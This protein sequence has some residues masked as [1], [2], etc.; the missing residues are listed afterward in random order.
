MAERNGEKEEQET[1]AIF[2][3]FSLHLEVRMIS[4]SLTPLIL[5]WSLPLS[6]HL[7]PIVPFRLSRSIL[8]PVLLYLTQILRATDTT[9]RHFTP[10]SPPHSPPLQSHTNQPSEWTPLV[11]IIKISIGSKP[12]YMLQYAVGDV[13]DTRSRRRE[14]SFLELLASASPALS[15]RFRFHWLSCWK[16][17]K[18][19]LYF[20]LYLSSWSNV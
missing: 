5:P 6:L 1:P 15:V 14:N 13:G 12:R 18:T 20:F 10:Q 17:Q 11:F 9:W 2:Q 7:F 3:I 8:P 4:L 19:L 16:R